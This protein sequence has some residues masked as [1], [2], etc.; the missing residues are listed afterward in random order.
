[1]PFL[2]LDQLTLPTSREHW[3]AVAMVAAGQLMI[4]DLR[5][6]GLLRGGPVIDRARCEELLT[7]AAANDVLVAVD[8]AVEAGLQ[9]WAGWNDPETTCV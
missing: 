5:Q 9:L 2:D 8:Q 3:H 1:M 6:H 4:D 7:F